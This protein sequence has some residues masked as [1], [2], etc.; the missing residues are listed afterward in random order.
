MNVRV[1]QSKTA[2]VL[3]TATVVAYFS[4]P[5]SCGYVLSQFSRHD[6]VPYA[7]FDY[8]GWGVI[9]AWLAALVFAPPILWLASKIFLSRQ[10]SFGILGRGRDTKTTTYSIL[11]ALGLGAPMHSQLSYLVG[12]PT[13]L[14]LPILASSLAWLLLVEIGRTAAV[15]GDVLNKVAGRTAAAI[16]LL[17]SLPKFAL[18]GFALTNP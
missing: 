4:R 15:R 2:F 14:T 13:R 16:A 7:K 17:I 11:V 6:A 12:L 18:I 10:A 1:A 3:M 5:W 8:H 9:F